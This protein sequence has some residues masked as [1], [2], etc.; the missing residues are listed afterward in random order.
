MATIDI[1]NLSGAKV[2]TLEL[3]DEIFSAVNEDLLWESII[4]RTRLRSVN[5]PAMTPE[6]RTDGPDTGSARTFL[7]PK[8]LA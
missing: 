4:I 5:R 2:G 1:Q 7:L 3:A 8:F 6:R